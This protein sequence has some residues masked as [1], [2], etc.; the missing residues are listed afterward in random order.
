M[1]TCKQVGKAWLQVPLPGG[2]TRTILKHNL[3]IIPTFGVNI[4]PESHF[5]NKG[6]RIVKDRQHS[7]IFLRETPLLRAT[8]RAGTDLHYFIS[9]LPLAKPGGQMTSDP[10]TARPTKQLTKQPTC[11]FSGDSQDSGTVLGQTH[12]TKSTSSLPTGPRFVGETSESTF[13]LSDDLQRWLPTSGDTQVRFV[14]AAHSL[15]QCSVAKEYAPPSPELLLWHVRLG[16]RNFQDVAKL[17]GARLPAKPI[18]CSSCV[19]GKGTRYPL[20]KRRTAPLHEAPR[21]GY[22]FHTD[23]KG[24]FSTNTRGGNRYMIIHVDDYSRKVFV[25]LER[26]MSAYYERHIVGKVPIPLTA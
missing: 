9:T 8:H 16:H 2:D 13:L 23:I 5:L 26:T 15:D 11:V 12:G 20:S 4:M 18:F 10:T 3:R 1:V 22:M 25:T 17:I 19:Q 21:P 24:P 7:D 14:R 6:C